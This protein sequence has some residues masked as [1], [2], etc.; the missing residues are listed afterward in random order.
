MEQL[1]FIINGGET[2]RYHT[3]PVLR[4]DRVDSHSFRVAMLYSMMALDGNE[5]TGGL[6]TPG[7]MAALVHDLA[8]HKTGDLPAPVKRAMP[9]GADGVSFRDTWGVMENKLLALAG[10][11]WEPMLTPPQ[12]RW[13]KL[14]DAMDGALFCIR[15]R[16][17]GNRLIGAVYNN[18][19]NYVREVA[20]PLRGDVEQQIINYIDDMWEQANG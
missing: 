15:E 14:A 8:E 19:W 4:E 3:Q 12:A 7:L 20:G 11:E 9:P 10:L 13:L 18:F 17:M 1:D 16:M 6:T 2:R 5:S